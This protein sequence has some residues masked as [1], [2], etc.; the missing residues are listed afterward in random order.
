MAKAFAEKGMNIA[1]ADIS[2][3]QLSEVQAEFEA[4]N[5][6][7]MT[8]PLD[9]TDR[10]AMKQA[11]SEVVSHFGGVNIVC[12]NAGVSGH[13]GPIEEGND[14][15]WD[16]VI[17]VN[18]KGSVNTI[19][20]FLPHLLEN[21]NDGH[22]VITSSISGLRVH[23]PSRGQCM[24]NTTKFAL[25]GYSEALALDLEPYGIGVSVVCP[26]IV[27]T[28]I[29][30]SG[31][32]RPERY[33]GAVTLNQDHDLAKF[34]ASGTDPLEFGHWIVRAIELNRLFVLTHDNDRDQ[35][36]DRHKRIMAAFDNMDEIKTNWKIN[37]D[38]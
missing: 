4:Q 17:D 21:K 7:V 26:G 31:R 34:A 2:A 5:V 11:A 37:S 15:D 3:Q 6:P 36:E 29:S 35:V 27:N 13:M 38:S 25:V 30:N 8:F 19:Q 10:D 23:R 16:W 32:N 12:A 22:I 1:L 9:V 14:T 33:G 24:Y 28:D 20:A 18:L